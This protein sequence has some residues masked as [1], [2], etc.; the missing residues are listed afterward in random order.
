MSHQ[1]SS[2]EDEICALDRD[3]SSTSLALDGPPDTEDG[4]T[5][6]EPV[7]FY[8]APEAPGKGPCFIL[9]RGSRWSKFLL[10][11]VGIQN[12]A[13]FERPNWGGEPLVHPNGQPWAWTYRTLDEL[14]LDESRIM[15]SAQ[16]IDFMSLARIAAGDLVSAV[17]ADPK[18]PP[19][20]RV[21]PSLVAGAGLST[22]TPT[23]ELFQ[24][25]A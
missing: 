13:F 7:R 22:A 10:A 19:K 17:T 24:D 20:A 2:G 23:M 1:W 6:N 16:L 11:R 18:K 15:D 12:E 9:V 8:F 4:L 5:K 14:E 21:L 3:E 25:A